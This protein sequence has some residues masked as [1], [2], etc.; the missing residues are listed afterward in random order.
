MLLL[1]VQ[2]T[3]VSMG[4]NVWKMETTCLASVTLV[5]REANVNAVSTRLAVLCWSAVST[6]CSG[7]SD[8]Y[9]KGKRR[10]KRRKK[11]RKK[12]REGK[13]TEIKE[14]KKSEKKERKK[15]EMIVTLTLSLLATL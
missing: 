3:S 7:T 9:Q 6:A 10:K 11:K 12:K 13:K 1:G 8:G 14:R 5:T 2:V 15:E 4:A